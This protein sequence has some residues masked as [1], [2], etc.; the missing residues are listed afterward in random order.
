MQKVRRLLLLLLGLAWGVAAGELGLHAEGPTPEYASKAGSLA[1]FLD[2]V[3]WPAGDGSA[4]T[5][6]ILGDD[7]FGGALDKLHV[8]RS[9]KVEELK[10]CQ[11]IFVA[12]SEQENLN[13]MLESLGS[14]NILT[15]GESEGFAKQGGI[16]GFVIDGDKVRFEINTGAARRAGLKI[17]LRLLK[18]AV[19]VFNS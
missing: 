19:R 10:D 13:A 2:Y 16:I 5:V 15:V 8:K 9:R 3:K 7:P 12:K 17:D 6:G 14:A 11:I 4:S 18:L 1:L